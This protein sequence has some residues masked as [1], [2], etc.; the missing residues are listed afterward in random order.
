MS[1][2]ALAVRSLGAIDLEAAHRRAQI[3]RLA[4]GMTLS[5]GV[6]LGLAWPLSFITPVVAAK[7]LTRP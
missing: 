3:F 4:F 7:L 2:D 5:A 6:A 1:A